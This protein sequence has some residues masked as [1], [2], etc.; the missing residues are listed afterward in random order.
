MCY[1]PR[2]TPLLAM[3]ASHGW[4]AIGG[5]EAMVEQG[6]AQARMWAATAKAFADGK[7]HFDPIPYAV[8]AGDEGPIGVKVEEQAREMAKAMMDIKV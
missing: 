1:K 8:K 4:F 6:L 7:D 5:V 3:A 2:E